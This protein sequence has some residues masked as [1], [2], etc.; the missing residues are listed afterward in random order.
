MTVSIRFAGHGRSAVQACML[1]GFL[2]GAAWPAAANNLT[3]RGKALV[4]LNCS[5]CHAV[6]VTGKSSHP[7]APAFRVL[8]K[9]Y[10]ITDLEEALAEGISTGHPDMP[11]WIASPDQIDAIIAYISSIQQP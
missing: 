5:G 11:E 6:G 10:P 1:M 2:L 8:S 9:R 4:E 7:A 3:E